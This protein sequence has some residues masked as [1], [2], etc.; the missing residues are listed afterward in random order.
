MP[1]E[2]V[3]GWTETIRQTLKDDGVAVNGTGLTLGLEL[4]DREGGAVETG[5]GKT[6]WSTQVSGIAGF[7]PAAEDLVAT[8]GPYKA[9]WVVTSGSTVVY[10]P[11]G[12]ADVWKVRAK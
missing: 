5:G 2:L 1:E 8:R 12:E 4:H 10:Y 7:T 6:A 9:R 3:E 11:N